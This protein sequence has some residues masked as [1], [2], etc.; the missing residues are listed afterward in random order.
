MPREKLHEFPKMS[1]CLRQGD[2]AGARGCVFYPE[3]SNFRGGAGSSGRG[4]VRRFGEG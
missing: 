2:G 1:F 3:Q 4:G